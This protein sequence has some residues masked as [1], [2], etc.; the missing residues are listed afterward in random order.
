[1]N[2]FA[3]VAFPW[4][5]GYEGGYND[6]PQDRGNWTGG[7][8]GVGILAGTK[9]GISAAAYPTLDIKNLTIADALPIAKAHYWDRISGDD[10]PAPIALCLF[11]FAYNAGD[12]EAIVVLQRALGVT[13][14]GVLG[15][16]TKSAC[17]ANDPLTVARAFTTA[18]LLAYT[19]M[20]EYPV[21]GVGWEARANAT[22][23]KALTC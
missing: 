8:V 22:L 18:R 17:S 5:L 6:D 3:N 11:D 13:Q 7:Q 9:Y 23:A 2:F 1:M 21:Y 20:K 4:I 12:H 14:D 19:S 15:P 16:H 10:L